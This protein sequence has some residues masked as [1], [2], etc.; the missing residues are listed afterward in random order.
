MFLLEDV[1]LQVRAIELQQ[2]FESRSSATE[3]HIFHEKGPA[4]QFIKWNGFLL[5]IGK[6]WPFVFSIFDVRA[7]FPYTS[8]NNNRQYPTVTRHIP[9]HNILSTKSQTLFRVSYLYLLSNLQNNLTEDHSRP[10]DLN[11]RPYHLP[12]LWAFT[13]ANLVSFFKL[14]CLLFCNCPKFPSPLL[15]IS[16]ICHTIL[17]VF[18]K[19][20][21]KENIHTTCF[22]HTSMYRAM[23]FSYICS[24]FHLSI[25]VI[26]CYCYFTRYMNVGYGITSLIATQLF[27]EAF[28][29]LIS[30]NNLV[31]SNSVSK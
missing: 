6:S 21:L 24:S 11:E 25:N 23:I 15:H 30:K 29:N 22:F 10:Q 4:S 13:C 5:T 26:C 17:R 14:L 19:Q 1:C 3:N 28:N 18:V 27:C 12:V 20:F 7:G 2:C 9:T 31:K 8:E 16:C